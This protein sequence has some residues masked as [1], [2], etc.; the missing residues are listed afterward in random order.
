MRLA[1]VT[2]LEPATF[3]VTGHLIPQENQRL[4]RLLARTKVLEFRRK[5]EQPLR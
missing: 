2:G 4:F 3:G 5:S 1:G